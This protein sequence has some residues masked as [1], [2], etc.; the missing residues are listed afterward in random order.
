MCSAVILRRNA[1]NTEQRCMDEPRVL[2]MPADVEREVCG[3]LF[4]QSHGSWV[5]STQELNVLTTLYL[6]IGNTFILKIAEFL[7][8][9][10]VFH[11][12]KF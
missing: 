12:K 4:R 10:Q 6:Y 9:F 7:S 1:V 3:S 5:L 11:I 2:S 8:K